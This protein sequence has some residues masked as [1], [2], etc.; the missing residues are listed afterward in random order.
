MLRRAMPV[1]VRYE[2]NDGDTRAARSGVKRYAERMLRALAM[3]DAELS[4]LLCDDALMHQLNHEHRNIDR[5]T[6][7]LAFAMGEGA[8][9]A[10]PKQVL[11]DIAISL[12]TAAKQAHEHG[13]PL[14]VEV[15][16]LLAHG[17]LHVLGFD[18]RTRTEERRMMARAHL[19]MASALP[20][21]VTVEKRGPAAF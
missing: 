4:L 16:L 21:P 17:L 7:V 13:W 6:D 10:S 12:P 11:G 20:S 5:T 19:L 15:C 8:A 18:H 1:F 3:Q 14:R 2:G 9:M